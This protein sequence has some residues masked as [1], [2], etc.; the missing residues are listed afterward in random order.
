MTLKQAAKQ[1]K[2]QLFSRLDK[3]KLGKLRNDTTWIG[4]IADHI[5]LCNKILDNKITDG[6]SLDRALWNM[7]TDSRDNVPGYIWKYT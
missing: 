5:H 3:A 6:R 4:D 7:D 2:K 1:Y